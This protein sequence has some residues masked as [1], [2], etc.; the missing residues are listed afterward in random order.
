MCDAAGRG[1]ML[2]MTSRPTTSKVLLVA[3]GRPV[4]ND[5]PAVPVRRFRLARILPEFRPDARKTPA[6]GRS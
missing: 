3:E 5:A 6:G 1:I 2:A 4:S